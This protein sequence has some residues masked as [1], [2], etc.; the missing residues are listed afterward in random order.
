MRC[1][2]LSSYRTVG[3]VPVSYL[4]SRPGRDTK[5][6]PSNENRA[7]LAGLTRHIGHSS[8]ITDHGCVRYVADTGRVYTARYRSVG[9]ASRAG[10]RVCGVD[11]SLISLYT[12]L[13]RGLITVQRF[14]RL[15]FWVTCAS[16]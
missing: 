10:R 12:R 9:L 4:A 11:C 14:S 2:A 8:P 6:K 5:R 1:T 13:I 16:W 3:S 7:G 15:S